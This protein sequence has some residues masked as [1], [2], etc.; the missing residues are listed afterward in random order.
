MEVLP[1][2]AVFSLTQGM[3][4]RMAECKLEKNLTGTILLHYTG[5]NEEATMFMGSVSGLSAGKHGF[6]VHQVTRKI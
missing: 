3:K 4:M 1:L 2:L 6:H 5:M